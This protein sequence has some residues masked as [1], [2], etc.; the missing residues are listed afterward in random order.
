MLT[1]ISPAEFLR[2]AGFPPQ[3]LV[4]C[5]GD[6]LTLLLV[7]ALVLLLRTLFGGVDLEQYIWMALFIIV[8]MPIIG[9][10]FGLYQTLPLPPHR[11]L[12]SLVLSAS[13]VFAL[14]L[15]FL[16]AGKSS[17]SYS[18]LALLGGWVVS[19]LALP[20]WRF[21]AR[22]L[23]VR[24]RWWGAP[25]IILDRSRRGRAFW[26]YLKRN[27]QYGLLPCDIMDL[28]EDRERLATCLE[29]CAR[30]YPDA[31]ALLLH[32]GA[33]ENGSCL[34]LVS[35][36]FGKTLVVPRFDAGM[37]HFWLT[38]CDLGLHTGL[39]VKQN[40]RSLWRRRLKRL[41][42]LSIC[43][44]LS[45]LLLLPC[46]CIVLAICLDSRG[47][48]IYRQRR[49][50]Q[51]GREIRICKF[52]TM[53]ADADKAL[54][55]YLEERPELRA[56]W[57]HDH[58][59]KHDP[60]VTRVGAFLRKTSLDELPQLINVLAGEM[61]LVGPRPIVESERDKYGQVYEN[62]C[63]VR[64]GVTGLWQVSGRNNTSYAERVALDNYY[65]T[66]WSVWMDLWILGKTPF[67]VLTGYGAY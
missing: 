43:L 19:C 27:P 8:L 48:P 15:L 57:E 9:F 31:I 39:L 37:Q 58:K 49:I 17:M 7:S 29:N 25:L 18:R 5:L 54:A 34:S 47:A 38:P 6:T 67:V 1:N 23:W 65:V 41:L 61:S 4:L 10:L 21:L 20:G 45:V 55:R 63:R 26:H 40:L 59:L 24:R 56:E 50:G 2:R 11:E 66:N 33:Q 42:D 13:M 28:P 36:Y 3:Q 52:R 46:L 16:F 32:D 60:R 44:P 14:L 53:I 51:G 30:R 12:R 35:R 22:R 64:P 62:Y